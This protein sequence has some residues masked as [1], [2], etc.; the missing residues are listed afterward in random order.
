MMTCL[1]LYEPL[2]H[3]HTLYVSLNRVKMRAPID[4]PPIPRVAHMSP[5]GLW[6]RV[7]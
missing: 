4:A 3:Y 2:S 1:T 5:V 7:S 6:G